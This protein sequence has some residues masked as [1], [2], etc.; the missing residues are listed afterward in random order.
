M[1]VPRDP[2][3]RTKPW[4]YVAVALIIVAAVAVMAVSL[5]R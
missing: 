3:G 4:L 1:Y 5:V 2:E